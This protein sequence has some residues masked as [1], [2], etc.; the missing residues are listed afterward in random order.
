MNKT[1][2]APQGEGGVIEADDAKLLN[3]NELDNE[4]NY[5]DYEL[6]N[7]S[8]ILIDNTLDNLKLKNYSSNYDKSL[9]N[10]NRSIS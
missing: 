4:E 8:L 1:D 3:K 7:N 5:D 10:K 2:F 6:N 9:P